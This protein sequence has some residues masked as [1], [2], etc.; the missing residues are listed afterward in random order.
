MSNLKINVMIK[1]VY[2]VLIFLF[3]NLIS[4]AQNNFSDFQYWKTRILNDNSLELVKQSLA[5]NNY[6]ISFKKQDIPKQL[7]DILSQWRNEV[8]TIANPNENYNSTDAV[9]DSLPDRQLISI[10]RNNESVFIHYNHGGIG[11]HK[12]MIWCRII[13]KNITDIWICNSYQTITSFEKLKK[14]IKNF[15]RIISLKNGK[16]VKQNH[17]CY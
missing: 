12:H 8:F 10:F 14:E 5:R 11:H 6:V 1:I 9:N 7:I 4:L 16:K 15:S 2:I 17:L 3:S 13:N